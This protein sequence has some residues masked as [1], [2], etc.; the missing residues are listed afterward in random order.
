MYFVNYLRLRRFFF[1]FF[2]SLF[3]VFSGLFPP[4][5]APPPP[6]PRW[7]FAGRSQ[8][9]TRRRGFA[10][11][12]GSMRGRHSQWQP[13]GTG[14]GP[15]LSADPGVRGGTLASGRGP[16]PRARTPM[17]RQTPVAKALD[18]SMLVPASPRKGGEGTQ[19]FGRGPRRS[20]VPRHPGSMGLT[21]RLF[22]FAR[23]A[24][25]PRRL[26]HR[27]PLCQPDSPQCPP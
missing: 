8:L 14:A 4:D 7:R 16:W 12:C 18:P 5:P 2:F 10:R 17:S 23:A 25:G 3:S 9:R 19:A 1:F 22:V 21:W 26:G 24:G 11:D 20:G 15:R 13:G 27:L 6:P